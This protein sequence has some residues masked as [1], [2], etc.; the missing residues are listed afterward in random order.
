MDNSMS[1]LDQ[2]PISK[3]HWE[4]FFILGMGLQCNGFLNSS[5]SSILADLVNV[6]WS[7]NYLNAFFSSAMMAG[8]F[9]GSLFGGIIGDKI[10]RKKSYEI[11]VLIFGTFALVAAASPNM[12]F[13]IV[14]RCLMGI[15]MGAGI[16][17]GYGT[18]TELMP[19][20]VRGKWSARISFLGNLSP[21]I[22]T[23]TAFMIIP[24]L[25][26][27]TIFIIG[28][29]AAFIILYFIKRYLYESPRWYIRNGQVEKGNQVIDNIVLDIEKS[30]HTKLDFKPASENTNSGNN[31]APEKI[32]F[33]S[34]F[35]GSLGRRLLVS[36]VTLV[37]MD[38]SLYTVTV[39]IPTIF[40][41]NG[42]NITKSLLMTMLV[43]LGAPL[44]VFCSTFII[45]KF[46]RKWFGV[47]LILSIAILGYVYSIQRSDIG[48]ILVGI[49]LTFILY[50]YN[51]F[52]SAVYAP[53]VWPTKSKMRG[54]GIADAIGR[55]AA[56]ITPYLIAWLLTDFGQVIVF[57]VIGA[58]LV[59]CALILS[60]FGFET[61]NVPVEKI[62][63]MFNDNTEDTHEKESSSYDCKISKKVT[64]EHS[65]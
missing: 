36:S 27:R 62:E 31:T 45:D 40:V 44:G 22:A 19:A 42:F 51:A 63:T 60:I 18:F 54:L 29:I 61:R 4:M 30:K 33:S 49:V 52:S 20:R 15:G 2:L 46:P 7:N 38:L 34:F 3:W 23:I 5:G 41:N 6:G 39:W 28:G 16:V 57:A 26:W 50:I 11:C 35:H 37:A 8:F 58:L 25:G 47:S 21:I 53:E 43:M 32:K 10:G 1:K 64:L 14:C 48:I 55:I 65:N 9:I 17:I 12:Y 24:H 56:I 59:A 13:L